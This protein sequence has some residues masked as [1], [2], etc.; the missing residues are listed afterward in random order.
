MEKFSIVILEPQSDDLNKFWCPYTSTVHQMSNT[1]NI[2]LGC[3]VA[4]IRNDLFVN[5]APGEFI[6]VDG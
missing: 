4:E 3:T 5:F 1:F 6:G 2:A